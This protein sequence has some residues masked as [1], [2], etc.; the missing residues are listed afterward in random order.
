MLLNCIFAW[1]SL[2]QPLA[3]VMQR[4]V[5]LSISLQEEAHLVLCHFSSDTWPTLAK[6]RAFVHILHCTTADTG[7]SELALISALLHGSYVAS[8][9]DALRKS[10]A[11]IWHVLR[12]MQ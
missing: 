1:V 4:F 7:T 3:R 5:V 12:R 10:C 6:I 8:D 11:Q 2:K 9:I